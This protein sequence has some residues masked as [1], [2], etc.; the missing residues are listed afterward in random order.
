MSSIATEEIRTIE[1]R[2]NIGYTNWS[3]LK[4]IQDYWIHFENA[5]SAQHDATLS[6][7]LKNFIQ[8]SFDLFFISFFLLTLILKY[9]FSIVKK[10]KN[11]L[12]SRRHIE[13]V[14][15]SKWDERASGNER[16]RLIY[17]YVY[18]S[19]T[20]VSVFFRRCT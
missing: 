12:K 1:T 13:R 17:T 8:I 14:R 2:H 19:F 15:S 16:N 11:Q 6:N 3:V 10:K 7:L 20:N 5:A 18:F 9:N 4:I